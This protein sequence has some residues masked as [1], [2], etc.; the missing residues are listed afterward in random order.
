MGLASVQEGD[1]RDPHIYT[2]DHHVVSKHSAPLLIAINILPSFG[3]PK[4]FAFPFPLCVLDSM[5]L[6]NRAHGDHT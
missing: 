2:W 6:I 1:T 4:R 5:Q 3:S